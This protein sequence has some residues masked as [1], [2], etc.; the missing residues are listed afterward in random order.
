MTT[1]RKHYK[2]LTQLQWKSDSDYEVE[3]VAFGASQLSHSSGRGGHFQQKPG[4]GHRPPLITKDLVQG[5][6]TGRS[7]SRNRLL[8]NLAII[9]VIWVLLRDGG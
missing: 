8:W 7:L 2:Q 9:P 1:V 5:W 6:V 3:A 4:G